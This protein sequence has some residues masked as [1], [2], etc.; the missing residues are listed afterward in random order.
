ML[1]AMASR[2]PAIAMRGRH[3]DGAQ[4]PSFHPSL[5]IRKMRGYESTWEGRVTLGYVFTF[6]IE[7]DPETGETIYVFRNIGKHDIYRSP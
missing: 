5:R 4:P 7:H 1:E 6:H 3:A 2:L